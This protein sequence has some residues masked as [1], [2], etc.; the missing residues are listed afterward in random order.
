MYYEQ[1]GS[2]R[3]RTQ[4]LSLASATDCVPLCLQAFALTVRF[5]TRFHQLAYY[6]NQTDKIISEISWLRTVGANT[7]RH[8]GL[9]DL[10]VE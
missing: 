4:P 1:Y 10:G 8:C 2:M 3:F 9:Q 7:S 6:L 5:T